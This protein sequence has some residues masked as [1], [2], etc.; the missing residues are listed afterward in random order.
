MKRIFN[1][2]VSSLLTHPRLRR[3]LVR[4]L[5][6]R[7]YPELDVS[8]PLGHGLRAPLSLPGAAGA[9]SHI[10]LQDEYLGAFS[11]GNLPSRWI[12]LG[13]HSGYFSLY[14]LW[15]H[16]KRNATQAVQA[17]LVDAD[18]DSLISVPQLI[19]L[20]R[21]DE[22]LTFAHGAIAR[23]SGDVC[24]TPQEHMQSAL[25]D[26]GKVTDQTI[27]VEILQPAAILECFPPPYDLIKADIEGA[28][29]DLLLD[30]DE[31]LRHT[32]QLIV[33]WHSWHPGGG[34]KEQIEAL[35]RERGFHRLADIVL[36]NRLTRAGAPAEC[37]VILFQ[38]S[39]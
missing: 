25:A 7:Y 26:H 8:V 17:L 23:G 38:R 24:F 31:V 12:D 35:A 36:V 10:F 18:P 3:R 14:L 13:C 32:R 33:E 4:E 19:K 9:F 30:Y 29:Y 34:G 15:L 2:L 11:S 39:A 20:N 28:E 21:L 16:R 22:Q 5:R 6:E 37:G 27:R 1:S